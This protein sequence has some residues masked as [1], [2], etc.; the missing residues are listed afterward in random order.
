MKSGVKDVAMNGVVVELTA[1][2]QSSSSHGWMD[3]W[4]SWLEK[5][6]QAKVRGD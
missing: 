3:G 6:P 5:C 4:M 2:L 1:V